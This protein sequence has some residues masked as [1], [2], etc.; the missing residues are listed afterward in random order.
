M[1][2]AAPADDWGRA[3]RRALVVCACAC[4]AAPTA[5]AQRDST[6]LLD[7]AARRYGA[8]RTLRA[9]FEQ[10]LTNPGTS[11]TRTAKGELFQRGAWQFALRYSDPAG[12]AIVSDDSTLWVY[13][14]STMPGQV[15]KLPRAAGA[16]F[17]FLSHLLS[18]PRA[19][20][21][22]H[23]AAG[24]PVPGHETAA[25][26]LVPKEANAPFTRARVWIGRADTLLWQVET[27]EVG[28]MVRRVRFIDI[29]PGAALPRT[30]L[31][32]SIPPGTRVID[33]AAL[34]GGR[35]GPPRP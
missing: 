26:D 13:L 2:I 10:T 11:G 14:P 5:T 8:M 28:G 19:H 18:A 22:V 6:A 12:D 7:R 21:T 29:R 16:G 27:V 17:D 9:T 25:F 30:Q 23:A 31:R 34:L 15:L 24:A 20:Y 1:T 33:Q 32:F 3:V 35:A 4:V